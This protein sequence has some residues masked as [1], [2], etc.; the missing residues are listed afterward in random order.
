MSDPTP[1][2]LEKAAY[3]L[4]AALPGTGP[5]EQELEMALIKAALAAE[6]E[7][8]KLEMAQEVFDA[9][10]GVYEEAAAIRARGEDHGKDS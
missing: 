2:D 4:W 9:L 6:R 5:E 1:A 8:G 3:D 7:A 10:T